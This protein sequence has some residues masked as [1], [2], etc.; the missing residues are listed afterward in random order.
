M[1]YVEAPKLK[2]EWLASLFPTM[3]VLGLYLLPDKG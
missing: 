3:K 1:K 2:V